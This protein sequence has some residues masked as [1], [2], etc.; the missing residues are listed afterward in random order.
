MSKNAYELNHTFVKSLWFKR[1][2]SNE[3][4]VSWLLVSYV[5]AADPKENKVRKGHSM[6]LQRQAE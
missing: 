1:V 4:E 5:G 3:L 2:S 6:C